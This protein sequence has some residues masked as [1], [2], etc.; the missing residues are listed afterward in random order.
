MDRI[1][2]FRGLFQFLS[3]FYNAPVTYD[4]ITYQNNEAAF[5]AQKTKDPEIKKIFKNLGPSE[6]KRLGRTIKLRGDWETVKDDIMYEICYAKFSQN[7]HLALKLI[8]TNGFELEEGNTWGDRYWG[9]VDGVGQNKL[10]LILMRVRDEI[11]E[12]YNDA[13]NEVED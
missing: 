1:T 13:D 7:P 2:N 3:N 11:I 5:Q 4:D 8:A 10:G 9:T 6:A 12:E